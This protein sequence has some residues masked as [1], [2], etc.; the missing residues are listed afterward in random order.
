M[1]CPNCAAQNKD[2]QH[3]CRTCGLQLDVISRQVAE[4]FPSEEYASLARRRRAFEIIGMISLSV[5]VLIGLLFV[6]AQAFYYK[7]IVF[8]PDVLFGSAFGALVLFALISVFFFNYPKL[9]M[10]LEPTAL[11]PDKPLDTNK[12]IDDRQFEPA[13]VTEHTTELL[14]SP[15]EK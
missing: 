8:G 2:D 3:Y 9:F 6:L 7:L 13:S 5:A 4:Q 10:K 11:D 14:S 12:L 15:R 1:F